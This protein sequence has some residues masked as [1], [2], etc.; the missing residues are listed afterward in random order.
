MKF[1]VISIQKTLPPPEMMP[2]LVEGLIQWVASGKGSGKLETIY[3][4]AG[5]SGG[6][7]IADVSSGEEL[8]ELMLRNPWAPFADIQIFPLSDIDSAMTGLREQVK[9]MGASRG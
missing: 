8:D 2:T 9:K 5:Q 4:F 6:M 3:S 1:L 7:S